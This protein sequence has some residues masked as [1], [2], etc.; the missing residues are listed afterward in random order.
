MTDE[1]YQLQPVSST[2]E[3]SSVNLGEVHIQLCFK[4]TAV[5]PN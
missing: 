1:W 2:D 4:K 5:S 3:K